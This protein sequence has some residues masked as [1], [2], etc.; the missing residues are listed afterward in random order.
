M[1]AYYVGLLSGD[2]TLFHANMVSH[3]AISIAVS[4]YH[5]LP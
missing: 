3:A 1:M 2:Y 5:M 4:M